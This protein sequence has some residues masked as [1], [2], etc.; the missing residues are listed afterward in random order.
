MIKER[1]IMVGKEQVTNNPEEQDDISQYERQEGSTIQKDSSVVNKCYKT[2]PSKEIVGLF[3]YLLWQPIYEHVDGLDICQDYKDALCNKFVS[4]R[5]DI[6][7]LYCKFAKQ[8]VCLDSNLPVTDTAY[9]SVYEGGFKFN[10][11]ADMNEQLGVCNTYFHE[12][13]H[14]LDYLMGNASSQVDMSSAIHQDLRLALN[15]LKLQL[16]CDEQTAQITLT[17]ILKR[18]VYAANVASDVFDGASNGKVFGRFRHSDNYWN[19]RAYDSLGKEAFA[20]ILADIACQ[21]ETH[22]AFTKQ[23]LPNTILKFNNIMKG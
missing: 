9:F 22:I 11:Y 3:E 20:E 12:S 6:K 2:K 17:S 16:Q 5:T 1:A 13:G 19:V 14:M 21:S 18:N 8:L 10:Q 23:Y 4:L 7:R 15:T